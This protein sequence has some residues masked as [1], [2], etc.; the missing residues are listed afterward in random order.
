MPIF[1]QLTFCL[2]FYIFV[3]MIFHL[4][5]FF[6]IFNTGCWSVPQ[7][8]NG[9]AIC[10]YFLFLFLLLLYSCCYFIFLKKNS[11]KT[12]EALYT[13]F[14]IYICINSDL[15]SVFASFYLFLKD[16]LKLFVDCFECYFML[17]IVINP[18]C[19]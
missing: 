15:F 17:K 18:S 4:I 1:F 2:T 14:L 8:T 5:I 19:R 10:D 3:L 11:P 7:I 12:L 16:Y 13:P 6:L 9:D